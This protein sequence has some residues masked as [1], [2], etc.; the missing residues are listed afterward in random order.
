MVAGVV[1]LAMVG[2][3][4]VQVAR[5][6]DGEDPGEASAPV[7]AD[8]QV[9]ETGSP[10]LSTAGYAEMLAAVDARLGSTD[11]FGVV[12][13]PTYGVLDLPADARSRA[14]RYLW[15]GVLA[16]AGAPSR[17]SP[18]GPRFDLRSVDPAV[19]AGVVAQAKERVQGPT[20]WYAVV[21]APEAG[22]GAIEGHATNEYGESAFV[23]ARPDGTAIR[24]SSPAAP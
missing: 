22:G 17:R 5:A 8:E 24:V 2:G 12:L 13:Y 16:E 7:E 6:L 10:V 18:D 1:L 23:L 9:A 15:D 20:L 3:G 11:A 14:H 4:V 19:V 21:R